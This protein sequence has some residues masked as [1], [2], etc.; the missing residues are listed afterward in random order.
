MRARMG[1]FNSGIICELREIIFRNKPA[2][3]VEISPKSTV[4]VLQTIDGVVIDESLDIML[5][6]LHQNDPDNWLKPEHGSID[7]MLLLINQNDFEFKEHLD[8]YKYPDKF[9]NVDP[10]LEREKAKEFLSI[11]EHKLT[12]QTYLCGAQI[13][14]ADFAIAPFIR[15]FAHVDKEWFDQTPYKALQVWLSNFLDSALFADVMGKH[16]LWQ[17]FD[18]PLLFGHIKN[19]N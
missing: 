10:H 3:M 6:A 18:E 9:D 15:Q 12:A 8:R 19:R 14:L 1:L 17:E 4:P 11:L 2:H 5:W 7:D 13:S 16:A